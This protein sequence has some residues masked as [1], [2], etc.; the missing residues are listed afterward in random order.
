MYA[1]DRRPAVPYRW[2]VV[3]P[4]EETHAGGDRVEDLG[5]VVTVG[6]AWCRAAEYEDVVSFGNGEP[7]L[8]GVDDDA[9]G[10]GPGSPVGCV[11]DGGSGQDTES[12]G[13]AGGE[14]HP[15]DDPVTDVDRG[16]EAELLLQRVEFGVEVVGA[17]AGDAEDHQVGGNLDAFDDTP[18]R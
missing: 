2:A 8:N 5:D 12:D 3:G 11:L 6:E 15:F 13:G 1:F 10:G 14:R 4:S 7:V 18:Q 16:L 9:A 17:V